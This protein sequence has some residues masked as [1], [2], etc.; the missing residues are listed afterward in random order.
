MSSERVLFKGQKRA[1]TNTKFREARDKLLP[2]LMDGE[3]K[4]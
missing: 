1:E 3:I 4:V 2:R